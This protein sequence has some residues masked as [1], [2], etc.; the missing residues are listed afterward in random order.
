MFSNCGKFS[1]EN[2]FM[3]PILREREM[4]ET[5]RQRDRERVI[6]DNDHG[7]ECY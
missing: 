1:L 3:V 2:S 5:E 4:R 7:F 6:T